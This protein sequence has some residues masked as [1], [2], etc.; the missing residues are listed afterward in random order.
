MTVVCP[1]M[2]SLM[3][4][5][6]FLGKKMTSFSSLKW[7]YDPSWPSYK[8]L[9]TTVRLFVKKKVSN[10]RELGRFLQFYRITGKNFFSESCISSF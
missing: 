1:F 4:V 8:K 3:L 6:L 10:D 9:Q 5:S 2:A 7:I